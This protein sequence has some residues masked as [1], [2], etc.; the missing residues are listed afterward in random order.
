MTS[1]ETLIIEI[2]LPP[3][4][5]SRF[6]SLLE[7]EDG[8]A[9]TRCFDPEHKKLQLWTTPGQKEDLL[10][11]LAALPEVLQVTVVGE[12]LWKDEHKGGPAHRALL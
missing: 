7:G 11:L 8:L 2:E 6:Q 4:Y 1:E 9:V 12:W 5:S 10:E 3:K